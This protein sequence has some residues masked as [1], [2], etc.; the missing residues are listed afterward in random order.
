MAVLLLFFVSIMSIWYNMNNNC[1]LKG[2]SISVQLESPGI[3]M[4]NAV[5]YH[6]A[7]TYLLFV[8][9]VYYRNHFGVLDHNVQVPLQ[10]CRNSVSF[11]SFHCRSYHFSCH[12]KVKHTGVYRHA[13]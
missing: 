10:Q 4:R 11:I 7:Y 6:Q 9:I 8:N 5:T 12:W 3:L 13:V 1:P 2:V